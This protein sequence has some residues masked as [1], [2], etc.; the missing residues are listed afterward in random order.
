MHQLVGSPD[1]IESTPVV[2]DGVMYFT[3]PRGRVL[4]VDAATGRQLWEYV[5]KYTYVGGGEGPLEQNRGVALLGN[6]VFVGTWDSKL[7]A[8]SAA[9]GREQWETKVGDYPGT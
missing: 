2:R 4:A 8:L 7:V 9:T 1:K 5:H 6:R 3:A